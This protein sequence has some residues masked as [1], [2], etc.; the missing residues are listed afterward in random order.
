MNYQT[1]PI[2]IWGGQLYQTA[3]RSQSLLNGST[4]AG[5]VE[6]WSTWIPVD[7]DGHILTGN[8]CG[9]PCIVGSDTQLQQKEL[10]VAI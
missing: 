1:Y 5:R 8:L 6:E 3:A 4:V 2:G 10:S 7:T 9:G